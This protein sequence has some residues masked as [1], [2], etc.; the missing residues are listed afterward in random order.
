MA[1]NHCAKRV[2]VK[3]GGYG[4]LGKTAKKAEVASGN[5]GLVGVP[6]IRAPILA[7]GAAMGSKL[8]AVTAGF[9]HP[10]LSDARLVFSGSAFADVTA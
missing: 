6:P 9:A 1:E 5:P 4:T 8:T 7:I 10:D 2:P 3:E